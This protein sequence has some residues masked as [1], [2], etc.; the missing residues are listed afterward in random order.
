MLLLVFVL[1]FAQGISRTKVGS[2]NYAEL[3][4]V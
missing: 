2:L 3:G 1:S 4:T